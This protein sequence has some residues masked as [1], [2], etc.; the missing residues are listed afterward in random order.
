MQDHKNGF[1]TVFETCVSPAPARL[2]NPRKILIVVPFGDLRP[3]QHRAKQLKHYLAQLNRLTAGVENVMVVVAEQVQPR[4]KFNGGLA[5]NSGVKW[6]VD[7]YGCPDVVVFND[8]DM[9]PDE[10]IFANYLKL[11]G[12]MYMVPFDGD[13]V[14]AYGMEMPPFGGGISGI[15]YGDLVRMNGYPN[16]LWGWG[17][18]DNVFDSRARAQGIGPV[19]YPT[20]GKVMHVD[21]QRKSN[22]AKMSYLTS[23][24][25]KIE[26]RG[27]LQRDKKTWRENGLAQV[28]CSALQVA[29]RGDAKV[30]S[31]DM[32]DH[33]KVNGH[34][35]KT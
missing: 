34:R 31:F 28:S 19:K 2:P 6:Y 16:D 1:I 20:S 35:Q 4:E 8:V 5:R 32:R 9:I 18:E 3:E 22:A 14:Q 29:T 13:F 24:A 23:T 15:L 21:A 27:I 25:A 11:T 10:E 7:A 30:V 12:P 26:D 33:A 17:Y